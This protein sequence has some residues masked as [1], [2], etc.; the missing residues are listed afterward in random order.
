MRT[1]FEKLCLVA[2]GS[3][4]SAAQAGDYSCVTNNSALTIAGYT[5]PSRL[6]RIGSP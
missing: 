5:G 4:L 6:Y 1:R 2:L 3:A